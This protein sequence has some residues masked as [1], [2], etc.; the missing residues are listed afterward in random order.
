[1]TSSSLFWLLFYKLELTLLLTLPL[2]SQEITFIVLLSLAAVFR[3]LHILYL[4]WKQTTVRIFLIDWEKPRSA[5]QTQD[6]PTTTPT[7]TVSI[8][9]TYFV[10]N[11]W[12]EIQTHRKFNP[13]VVL[14]LTLLLLE[15]FGLGNV[16]ER[17]PGI[18]VTTPTERYAAPHSSVLR[19]GLAATLY[20]LI[21]LI[22]VRG[23]EGGG[24]GVDLL[25]YYVH[26]YYY[27]S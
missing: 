19:I 1:M 18:Y 27:Y 17:D 25:Q 9:R 3:S 7:T 10:A 23:R 8:W 22:M 13:Y 11:E 4:I 12:N 2:P 6:T 24:E 15:V 16:A 26:Y 5:G 20:L 21:A 14:V